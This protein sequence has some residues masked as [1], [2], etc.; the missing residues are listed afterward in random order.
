MNRQDRKYAIR[1]IRHSLWLVDRRIDEAYDNSQKQ[2][3]QLAWHD[4]DDYINTYYVPLYQDEYAAYRRDMHIKHHEKVKNIKAINGWFSIPCIPQ[5]NFRE[6]LREQKGIRCI[7]R[8]EQVNADN[9]KLGRH[10]YVMRDQELKSLS[11]ERNCLRRHL[12]NTRQ[13]LGLKI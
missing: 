3:D 2:I 4:I 7:D 13:K 8:F 1:F 5:I 9:R 11:A 12:K 6:Y 10:F